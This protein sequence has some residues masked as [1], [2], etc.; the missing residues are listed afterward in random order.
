MRVGQFD[1]PV[2]YKSSV[3]SHEIPGGGAHHIFI[4]A[5]SIGKAG[6]P[7][8]VVPIVIKEFVGAVPHNLDSIGKA[9]KMSSGR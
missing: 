5:E 9:R 8:A 3:R 7:L 6:D 2:Q 4:D 1:G